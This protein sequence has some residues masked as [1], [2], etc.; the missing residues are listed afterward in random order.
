[1]KWSAAS[2]S[3][4]RILVL[5]DSASARAGQLG[6]VDPVKRVLSMEK[7]GRGSCAVRLSSDTIDNRIVK[8]AYQ[9]VT[10]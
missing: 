9:L 5:T 8:V 7:N 10:V 2:G 1:M 4:A 6:A 3:A